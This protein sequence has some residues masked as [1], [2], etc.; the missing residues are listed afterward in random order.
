MVFLLVVYHPPVGHA[1]LRSL[2]KSYQLSDAELNNCPLK[3]IGL[4]VTW[5]HAGIHAATANIADRALN[6]VAVTE[7]LQRLPNKAHTVLGH[8]VDTFR[9]AD[10]GYWAT[11]KVPLENMPKLRQ[12][13]MTGV[14]GSVSLTHTHTARGFM[15][16]EIAL[17][18]RPAR[19]GSHIRLVTPCPVDLCAYKGRVVAGTI[20]TMAT[21][22]PPGTTVPAT[23]TPPSIHDAL[24]NLSAAERAV[25]QSRLQYLVSCM[26]K[27]QAQLIAANKAAADAETRAQSTAH[28]K[29]D[30]ALMEAQLMQLV[31]GLNPDA[32]K[33]LGVGDIEALTT[34]FASENPH[35]LQNAALRTIMCCNQSMMMSQIAQQSTVKATAEQAVAQADTAADG[36]AQHAK[37]ARIADA[38]EPETEAERLTR[39]LEAQFGDC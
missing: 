7:A 22:G 38:G 18:T 1:V 25:V 8:V 19:P 13:I 21:A 20:R 10:G 15:P 33:N 30:N 39:A 29:T 17:V 26:D 37:R 27:S 4:P 11:L 14:L 34:A 28:A 35:V 31:A 9:A 12:S 6:A 16:L 2:P 5:E 36:S 3:L 32:R 23:S 24:A